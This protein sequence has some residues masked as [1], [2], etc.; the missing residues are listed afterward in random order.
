MRVCRIETGLALLLVV[1]CA[2]GA[3]T[4]PDRAELAA[5][6]RALQLTA[7]PEGAAMAR[8]AGIGVRFTVRNPLDRAVALWGAP[9]CTLV[10]EVRDATTGALV[11][12]TGAQSCAGPAAAT[13]VAAR[14]SLRGT[15]RWSGPADRLPIPVGTLQARLVFHGVTARDTYDEARVE[16]AWTAPFTVTP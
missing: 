7:A 13:R 10:V 1:G 2:P 9:A 15:F 4:A 11:F 16:S 8:A 14:D 6:V 5:D 12:P 3:A